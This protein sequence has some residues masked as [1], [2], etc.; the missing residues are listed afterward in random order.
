MKKIII[1]IIVLLI[2]IFGIHLFISKNNSGPAM[3]NP[4][5]TP[6]P[7]S[8]QTETQPVVSDTNTPSQSLSSLVNINGFAFNPSVL[9][10]KVGTKVTWTNN[11]NVVHTITG[12]NGGPTSSDVNPGSKYSYTFNTTGTFPYHCAIHTSMH[13][14][15]KVTQ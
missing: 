14:S 12:D 8:T 13:G 2:I 5:T 3:E 1:F 15:V 4:I 10:V 6:A 11:D 7:A 9:N